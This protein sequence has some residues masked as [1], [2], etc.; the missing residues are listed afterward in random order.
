MASLFDIL[1]N[2]PINERR[3]SKGDPVRNF[4]FQ[5]SIEGVGFA[6]FQSVSGLEVNYGVH[7]YQEGG[8]NFSP[9]IF[10]D[11]VEWQP[12]VCKRGLCKNDT[13]L[14]LWA[15]QRFNTETAQVSA[16]GV[17]VAPTFMKRLC[18]LT[19]ADKTWK[20][21][22]EFVIYDAWVKSYKLGELNA[23]GNGV[24]VE[25]ISIVHNGWEHTKTGLLSELWA[26]I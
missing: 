18:M 12:L 5:L 24:L 11:Q 26:F 20:K 13:D 14:L 8:R 6:S 1:D 10:P 19:V 21:A 23:Q 16:F 4:R 17:H 9:R 2:V 15:R 25:E 3:Q 7:S 22:H